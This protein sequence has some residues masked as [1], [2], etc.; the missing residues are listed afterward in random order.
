MYSRLW[1]LTGARE[2]QRA[3]AETTDPHEFLARPQYEVN[4]KRKFPGATFDEEARQRWDAANKLTP[5]GQE[6]ARLTGARL[7]EM[8][9]AGGFRFAR[10]WHSDQTRAA[11]TA[12]LIHEQLSGTEDKPKPPMHVDSLIREGDPIQ[13]VPA[14]SAYK[15]AP[16]SCLEDGARIEAA[17]RKHMHRARLEQEEDSV[18]IVAAH[19]NVIRYFVCRAL[20]I[21]PAAWLRLAVYNTGITVIRISS[22][23]S[24]SISNLGD[25]G[26]LPADKITYH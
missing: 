4:S 24:V 10:V 5:M 18:E 11:E 9:D 20:Q 15:P 1:L 3:P 26:H 7:Q 2:R 19:G 21:P 6:Q 14:S 13:P 16:W 8:A 25:T 17:F 12:A 23:G 22:S